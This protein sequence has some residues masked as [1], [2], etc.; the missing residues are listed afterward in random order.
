M[1]FP[2]IKTEGHGS[3]FLNKGNQELHLGMSTFGVSI[4]Y[5]STLGNMSPGFRRRCGLELHLEDGRRVG[6]ITRGC[7]V[8]YEQISNEGT[9]MLRN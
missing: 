5:S 4:R 8:D 1:N 9:L 7:L 2:L 6:R 3:G